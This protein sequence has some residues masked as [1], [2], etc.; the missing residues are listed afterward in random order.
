L[1]LRFIRSTRHHGYQSANV[2]HTN[3]PPPNAPCGN[4]D[5]VLSSSNLVIILGM[6]QVSKKVDFEN[7]DVLN[8]V[9][10]LYVASNVIIAL[11]Y[12]YVQSQINKKKGTLR[13]SH[14]L[15]IIYVA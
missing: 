8:I 4:T 3:S 7:P 14:A 5:G 1:I 11:V 9:R 15:N 12:L 2:G 13:L 10:G 6:M